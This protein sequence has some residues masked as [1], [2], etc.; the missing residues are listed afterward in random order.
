MVFSTVFCCGFMMLIISN[1]YSQSYNQCLSD[2]SFRTASPIGES[3]E[4]TQLSLNDSVSRCNRDN[5]QI[6][7]LTWLVEKPGSIEFHFLDL[8]ELLSRK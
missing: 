3:A 8:V 2:F 4:N 6:T 5:Q 7:W 1:L